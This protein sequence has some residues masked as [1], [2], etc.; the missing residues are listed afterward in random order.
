MA[1]AVKPDVDGAA[2]PSAGGPKIDFSGLQLDD[3][4]LT[5]SAVRKLSALRAKAIADN[6]P[7]GDKLSLRIR[8]DGGGCSGF[9]YSFALESSG[10]SDEDRVFER[11]G[12]GAR[13]IVDTVSLDLIKGST[14]DWNEE[15]MRA[16]FS[17]VNNPNSESSCGCGSSFSAKS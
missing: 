6:K 15:M 3:L 9:K 10:P 1:A 16:S 2:T 8:V 7:N 13:V 4:L 12:S 17:I 5:P 11:V 14:V